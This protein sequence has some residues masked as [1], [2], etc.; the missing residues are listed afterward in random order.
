MEKTTDLSH[1]LR[2]SEQYEVEVKK[3]RLRVE[4]L[5]KELAVAQDE[6]DTVNCTVRKLQRVNEDLVEQ[7]EAT[8][9]QVNRLKEK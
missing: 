3:V 2:R 8:S 9:M 4:E 7:L 6:V 1:A 5:K